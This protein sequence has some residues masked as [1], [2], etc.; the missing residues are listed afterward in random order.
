MLKNIFLFYFMTHRVTLDSN[1]KNHKFHMHI[2]TNL[3][4]NYFILVTQY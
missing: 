2:Y 4:P 1:N 3:G